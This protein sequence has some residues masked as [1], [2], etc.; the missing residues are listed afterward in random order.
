MNFLNLLLRIFRFLGNL[1]WRIARVIF[2][3]IRR[4]PRRAFFVAVGFTFLVGSPEMRSFL[5]GL[6]AIVGLLFMAL[7]LIKKEIPGPIRSILGL[8]KKK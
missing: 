4:Y 6:G 8:G 2:R 5:I 1:A 3:L 7:N